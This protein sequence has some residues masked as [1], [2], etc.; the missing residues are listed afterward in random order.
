MNITFLADKPSTEQ[1]PQTQD[2]QPSSFV[3][4]YLADD[5]NFAA[6]DGGG[7]EYTFEDQSQQPQTVYG[8]GFEEQS[9]QLTAFVSGFEEQSQRLE[10]STAFST[11]QVRVFSYR[12]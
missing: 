1:Q 9:Q 10:T 6:A 11:T 4:E 3:S 12:K 2:Y 7:S 5:N 8:S